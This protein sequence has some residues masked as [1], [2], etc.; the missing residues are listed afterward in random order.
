MGRA[1][2]MLKTLLCRSW[3][4]HLVKK[5]GTNLPLAGA[6]PGRNHDWKDMVRLAGFFFIPELRGLGMMAKY[7]LVTCC[8]TLLDR[9][10]LRGCGFRRGRGTWGQAGKHQPQREEDAAWGVW[11]A[12]ILTWI[13]VFE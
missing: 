1:V 4:L 3:T 11:A 6:A 7:D 10:A 9:G 12:L 5:R 8:K 13:V 2:T